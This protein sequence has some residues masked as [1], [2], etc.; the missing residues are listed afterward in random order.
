MQSTESCELK[1]CQG[2][3]QSERHGAPNLQSLCQWPETKYAGQGEIS[4]A[5]AASRQALPLSPAQLRCIDYSGGAWQSSDDQGS[6]SSQKILGMT[7]WNQDARVRLQQFKSLSAISYALIK[8]RKCLIFWEGVMHHT[9]PKDAALAS[10][11][12]PL[13]ALSWQK[14]LPCI[15]RPAN[16]RT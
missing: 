9:F 8:L 11:S 16:I 12:L 10:Q 6:L 5:M 13:C 3:L 2:S 14:I 15:G 1:R 7:G 4:E